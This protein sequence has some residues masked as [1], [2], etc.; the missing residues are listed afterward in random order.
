MAT[1][2]NRNPHVYLEPPLKCHFQLLSKSGSAVWYGTSVLDCSW[3]WACLLLPVFMLCGEVVL[4]SAISYFCVFGPVTLNEWEK[5]LTFYLS[6]FK[7]TSKSLLCGSYHINVFSCYS[8]EYL[9][10]LLCVLS[11]SSM[12]HWKVSSMIMCY[13]W[14]CAGLVTAP[15]KSYL[16]Q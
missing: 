7:D 6:L 1:V 3:P 13:W 12:P 15:H 11:E 8:S 9:L 5:Q 14:I 4:P 2:T 10:Y 16:E